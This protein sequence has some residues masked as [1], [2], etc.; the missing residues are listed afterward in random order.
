MRFVNRG[1]MLILNVNSAEWDTTRAY[2]F[3]LKDPQGVFEPGAHPGVRGGQRLRGLRGQQPGPSSRDAPDHSR[4]FGT[5]T[6]FQN[7]HTVTAFDTLPGGA[8]SLATLTV[9]CT[10]A[11]ALC[12][13]QEPTTTTVGQV[14]EHDYNNNF[15]GQSVLAVI[16]PSTV[17]GVRRGA[18]IVDLRRRHVLQPREP[19]RSATTTVDES[20]RYANPMLAGNNLLARNAF[21]YIA[22]ELTD[23]YTSLS[24]P[25]RIMSTRDGVGV[26]QSKLTAGATRNLQVTGSN[27]IP[28]NATA[29]ALNVTV[30]GANATSF[31]SVYPP[32]RWPTASRRPHRT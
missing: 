18:V 19:R 28:A 30:T 5:V 25:V 29:V 11:T 15:T 4:P 3:G 14:L 2:D 26:S 23:G 31:V 17:S 6:T 8:T 9:A 27:G 13:R 24:A 20:E 1:G 21:A 16:P 32:A 22:N 10:A 7:W 12:D